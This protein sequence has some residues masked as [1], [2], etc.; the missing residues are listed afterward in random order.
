MKWT[1]GS[2]ILLISLVSG[3]GDSTDKTSSVPPEARVYDGAVAPGQLVIATRNAATTWYIDSRGK[4]AGYEYDLAQVYA[5]HLGLKPKFI[6]KETLDDVFEAI[7]NGEADIAAAGLTVTPVRAANYLVGPRYF[8]IHQELVCHREGVQPQEYEELVDIELMIIK[9]SSYSERLKEIRQAHSP[10][11]QW[12][13]STR[14]STEELLDKVANK[15]IDCTVADSNIVKINRRIFP[16]LSVSMKL[17]ENQDLAL[18]VPKHLDEL[19]DDLMQWFDKYEGSKQNKSINDQHY[20]FF[21]KF[22]YVEF[23]TFDRR[24]KERL[25]K[26]KKYFEKAA[27]EYEI[28]VSVLIAQSYQESH[29]NPEAVSP[30]GVKGMMMLTQSTAKEVGVDD[31]L[32]PKQ[33]IMGGAQYLKNMRKRFKEDIGE[34]DR[35]MLALAAYNIGRGH[36]HDAQSL[37]RQLG[38]NP[39]L[40]LDMKKVLPLLTQ[41]KYYKRLKYG[42]ARGTEPVRYVQR[43]REYRGII[44]QTVP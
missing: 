38:L 17:T 30:T 37:A 22:D 39:Y 25:P 5:K 20:G 33:S 4:P 43:I 31:R 28:P 41:K 27:D 1:K 26:Y 23:R 36:M 29:W 9:G 21:S 11:L 40:W 18:F 19:H 8:E 10:E 32:D 6:V 12:K 44:E 35:L 2:L 15:K 34:Q 42:Y 13:E 16:E 14:F 24:V 7:E 3:C